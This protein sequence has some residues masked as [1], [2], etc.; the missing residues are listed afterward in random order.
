[1]FTLENNTKENIFG[2]SLSFSDILYVFTFGW[3]C[4]F[5][6]QPGTFHVSDLDKTLS[7][8]DSHTLGVGMIKGEDFFAVAFFLSCFSVLYYVCIVI[9]LFISRCRGFISFQSGC[10]TCTR[11]SVS[12][13][14]GA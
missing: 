12:Y 8:I 11:E 3:H 9:V 2:G 13:L 4:L 5:F 7:F 1:M 6:M 14:F 10:C